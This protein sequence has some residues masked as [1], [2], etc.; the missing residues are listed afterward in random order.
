MAFLGCGCGETTDSAARS[1]LDGGGGQGAATGG[2]AGD[3]GAAHAGR[4]STGGNAQASGGR[5]AS[6]GTAGTGGASGAGNGGTNPHDASVDGLAPRDAAPDGPWTFA[7]GGCVS[8]P[9]S[10]A[11]DT[12]QY[13][14][15]RLCRTGAG[16]AI[17]TN[18]PRGFYIGHL[19]WILVIGDQYFIESGYPGAGLN[20]IGFRITDSQLAGLKRGE[21]LHAYYGVP[22]LRDAAV[23]APP[24]ARYCG[25][26]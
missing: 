9:R 4:S 18:D 11:P 17:V 16:W 6:G 2:A 25:D 1:P 26:F 23:V 7:D 14:T 10:Q 21:A 15:A 13:C 24:N 12:S 8:L 20:E 3:G 19:M 22:P 5:A